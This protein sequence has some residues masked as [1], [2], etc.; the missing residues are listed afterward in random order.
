MRRLLEVAIASVD[1]ARAAEQGGADRLELSAA[2]ALGGLTPTLGTLLEV[3]ATV[4]LP[5]LVLIRPRAGGFAYHAAEL[6]VLER[7][8]DFALAHGADGIVTGVLTA[9]G[10]VDVPRCRRLREQIGKATAVFHRAF[11]VTA[12]PFVALEQ[13]IDL[14]FERVLTSGQETTAVDG[15]SR[16][17]EL[18]RQSGGRIEILPAAGIDSST[19]VEVLART[20]C[21]QVHASLRAF[22]EERMG[23]GRADLSFTRYEATNASAVAELR[24]LL[25]ESDKPAHGR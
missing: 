24:R 23:P 5:V 7:D 4:K 25:D 8:L 13:L 12:E 19:L 10:Q 18:I 6:R 21:T 20:G 22:R 11:D 3:K 9:D 16:L 14:G 17:A 1:D 2:L 15:A